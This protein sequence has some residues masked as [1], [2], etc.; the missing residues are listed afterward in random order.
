MGGGG[1]VLLDGQVGEEDCDFDAPHI[2]GMALVVKEDV[3]FNPTN[4]G[5]F[6]A[7]CILKFFRVY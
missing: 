2:L 3:A 4:V 7:I 1:D 5:L 6:G